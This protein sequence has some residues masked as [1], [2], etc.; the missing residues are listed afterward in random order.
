MML[1]N[2]TR[3]T[4]EALFIR[5]AALVVSATIPLE[6]GAY[7]ANCTVAELLGALDDPAIAQAVDAEVTR[8]QHSGELAGL[9]AAKLTDIML[10]KLLATPSEE[11]STSLA[12]KL[13]ELG[14]KFR[15][16][17]TTTAKPESPKA[18][19]IIL[20]DGDPDHKPNSDGGFELVIDLRNK[21]KT[22]RTIEHEGVTD[23]E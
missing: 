1:P 6:Q 18:T 22:A 13:A 7:F 20:R 2:S 12:M 15:E 17:T 3:A 16:R 5:S 19:L 14:L 21:L 8:L 4:P 23:A 9:K 11:I 10:D